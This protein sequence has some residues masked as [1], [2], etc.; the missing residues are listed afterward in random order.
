[1]FDHR[2]GRVSARPAPPR[3]APSEDASVFLTGRK[4]ARNAASAGHPPQGGAARLG[5]RRSRP[6]RLLSDELAAECHPDSS[7]ELQGRDQ[8]EHLALCCRDL[9]CA[10]LSPQEGRGR[11]SR[12]RFRGL[13]NAQVCTS[14]AP[15]HAD[16]AG[17]ERKFCADEFRDSRGSGGRCATSSS[18]EGGT[19][20]GKTPSVGRQAG[21]S[22]GRP[23]ASR[24]GRPETGRRHGRLRDSVPP[25]PCTCRGREQLLL[26]VPAPDREND[27]QVPHVQG[28]FL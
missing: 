13:K 21:R 1:M 6:G 27:L 9:R 19:L 11:S 20:C 14:R 4:G 8:H 10:G 5:P 25:P 16:S 26:W 15:W 23:R 7:G 28:V 24:R 2:P 3:T 12:G 17:P 18:T 22:A